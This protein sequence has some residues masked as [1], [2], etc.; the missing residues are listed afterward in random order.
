MSVKPIGRSR[1]PIDRGSRA[2]FAGRFGEA[3]CARFHDALNTGDPPADAVVAIGGERGNAIRGQLARGLAFGLASL[4][5]PDDV[6]AN[7]L[8]ETESVPDH[9]DGALIA[10]GPRA[11]Y[12]IPLRLHLLSM[13]AGALIAV[14]TSP[15]IASVLSATGRLNAH[16][17]NRL[18][19]T[20]RWLSSSM[21]PGSLAV[22]GAGYVATVELRLVHAH[23]RRAARRRGHDERRFGTAINQVDLARTWLAFTLTGMRAEA[24]LGFAPRE[25]EVTDNYGYWQQLAHLLGIEPALV[26]HV[27]THPDAERLE[28]SVQATSGEPEQAS[29][30]LTTRTLEAVASALDDVTTLPDG[31]SRKVL[32]CLVRRFHGDA[33]AD[34][35][36][37]PR[38]PLLGAL[39][40]PVA[41]LARAHRAIR[42]DDDAHW[43]AA[44]IGR[45]AD[46]LDAALADQASV[47][48]VLS[49]IVEVAR[50]TAPL[51][52]ATLLEPSAEPVVSAAA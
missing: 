38:T 51:P 20:A 46:A 45:Y 21:L 33:K 48:Q 35:L 24:S 27:R 30:T 9:V 50:A 12:R 25:A 7:L 26:G 18:R 37:V 44:A 42:H 19:D 13:S 16:T 32:A 10:N 28:E 17:G 41:A 47:P 43:N 40:T 23:A 49:P 39:M 15:S 22:G 11:W 3:S 31:A 29:V 8:R 1:W 52:I 14:Y 5:N 4:E 34:A 36:E 6:V 2:A